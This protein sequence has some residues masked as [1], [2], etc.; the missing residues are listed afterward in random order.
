MSRALYFQ[1]RHFPLC[2]VVCRFRSVRS[3]PSLTTPPLPRAF[4]STRE[5]A[6]ASLPNR[7]RRKSTEVSARSIAGEPALVFHARVSRGL[8][9]V[10]TR[11]RDL[12]SSPSFAASAPFRTASP[13]RR[14]SADV[15]RNFDECRART[16]S[17]RVRVVP[18][19][20][21]P[22]KSRLFFKAKGTRPAKR[23]ARVARIPSSRRNSKG[24]ATTNARDPRRFLRAGNMKN[25][26]ERI[27]GSLPG[28]FAGEKRARFAIE[29]YRTRRT[30]Y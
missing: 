16:N 21:S 7:G 17:P 25:A 27:P 29:R 14:I 6:V 26:N 24:T 22:E 12:R 1:A 11:P 28:D 15:S 20:E 30:A 10:N 23:N 9:R 19:R 5:S 18:S 13:R 2:Y 8:P 4:V 3:A